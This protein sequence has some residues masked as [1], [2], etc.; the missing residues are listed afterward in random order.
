MTL[1]DRPLLLRK[2]GGAYNQVTA[3]RTEIARKSTPETGSAE[4]L[5]QITHLSVTLT[6]ADLP[7]VC[8]TLKQA[9]ELQ[10]ELKYTTFESEHLLRIEEQNQLRNES[11]MTPA[12][13]IDQSMAEQLLMRLADCVHHKSADPDLRELTR[14]FETVDAVQR[15]IRRRRTVDLYFETTSERSQFKSQMT[16]VGCGVLLL[17]PVLLV[18]RLML[19]VMLPD[20]LLLLK[21]TGVLVFAPLFLFLIIQL[22]IFLAQ[23]AANQQ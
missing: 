15:S 11:V 4:D 19:G 18:V 1:K 12:A 2:L 17:T 21:L 20:Q 8:W 14:G 23:P 16:A 10:A 6:G 5:A 9:G 13:R 22:L 3:M 7:P